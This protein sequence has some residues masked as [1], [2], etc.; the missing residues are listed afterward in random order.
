MQRILFS[1]WHDIHYAL[2]QLRRSPG[3]ALT[4]VLTLALGVGANA[5]VFSVLNA[6]IL[7]PLPVPK[8][9][10]LVFL[11]RVDVHGPSSSSSN[12]SYPDYKDIRD[13][14]RSFSGTVAYRLDRVG[15]SLG[16]AHPET[17]SS[18]FITASENYFDVLGVQPLLGRY[19]H[20]SDARGPGSAPYVVLSYSFWQ[21]FAH[22]DRSVIGHTL[23]L[24]KQPFTVIGVAP[25]HFNGAELMFTPDFWVPLSE[26]AV[27]HGDDNDLKFR[28]SRGMW[29]LGRLR[30][31]VSQAQAG[32]DMRGI[33]SRLGAQYKEDE[34]NTIRLSRPGL[35]G[36]TFGSPV[37][38]FLFGVTLLAVLVLVAACANLGSLFAARA[39][40]RARELALRLALGASRVHVARQ[41][42][43]EALLL[44]LGGGAVG[45]A[46][47]GSA[48]HALSAWRPSA[49]LPIQVA[50]DPDLRVACVALAL[51][52]ASALFFGL[53]PL[54]QVWH[55]QAYLLIKS[56]SASTA[57]GRRWTLRDALLAVQIMLCAVLLTS[58]L[59][60]MRGLAR[61]LDAN[62][63]FNPDGVLLASFDLTTVGVADAQRPLLEQRAL[64][65][66]RTLPGVTA[67]AFVRGYPP[68]SVAG[69]NDTFMYRDGTTDLRPAN[70]VAGANYYPV[71]PDWF[72]AA[73]TPLLAGRE[74]TLRDTK[75]TP[76]VAVVNQTFA[77]RVLGPGSPIG[78][79][80]VYYGGRVEVVGLTGDGKYGSL[81][82]DP[83]PA[84]FFS[85]AQQRGDSNVVLIVR[86]RDTGAR[87][88]AMVRTAVQQIDPN[89]PISIVSWRE[90][91]R[92]VQFPAVAATA[93]LGVMGGL[94]AMLAIT[95]IFG[96]ASYAVSKRLRELALR[97]ALGAGRR[98]VLQAALGRPARLLLWGSL[99]GLALGAAASRL[100]AHVVYGASSLDPV[101]LGGVVAA[102]AGLA[103]G[104]SW[105]PA[106]RVLKVDPAQLLREE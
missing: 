8:A 40:D 95:G 98:E 74:F 28:G 45:Y 101:V 99:A 58:S 90:N 9:E 18:W 1:T 68:L 64:D 54:G 46:L 85:S 106:R 61:S 83:T 82:E 56:G 3:F 77:R 4:V 88:A 76:R 47:A 70:S 22:G 44:S 71:S 24:N 53:L 62:F 10:Q 12:Q 104:A 87:T 63:W 84:V 73:G 102:M 86:A 94:A 38:A 43:T 19:F 31:G 16:G 21:S 30:D 11:N 32:A 100:L 15:A 79:H 39:S 41:L 5:V 93:A 23:N 49:D 7:K 48:L 2:R 14:N 25:E 36:E 37:R 51:A 55:G 91:L 29:V 52:V 89:L 34:G 66:V 20:A 6:L 35:I 60:A 75:D 26:F 81:T 69:G 67:A 92:L 27:T 65:Q 72:A 105:L 13:Q 80:F 78:Q 42:V 59:V 57:K 97:V 103:L 50:V 33:A 17:R 96:M